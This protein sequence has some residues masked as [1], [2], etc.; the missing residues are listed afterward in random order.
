MGFTV[1]GFET[2]SQRQDEG[3]NASENERRPTDRRAPSGGSRGG[4]S[5][6]SR[7]G[8]ARPPRRDDRQVEPRERLWPDLPEDI[9]GDEL[10][11]DFIK[12]DLRPL[13][14]DNAR[15]VAK[16]LVMAARCIDEDPDLAWEHAQAAVRRAGRIGVVREAAGLAAYRAGHFAQALTELRAARRMTGSNEQLAV[17]ADCERAL[18]RPERALEI[19]GSAPAGISLATTVELRI[20]AAGARHDLGQHDAALVTVQVPELAQDDLEWGPRLR[21]AYAEA[22]LLVQRVDDARQWFLKAA[23]VDPEGLTDAEERA[24]ELGDVPRSPDGPVSDPQSAAGDNE[25]F[26]V[27]DLHDD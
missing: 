1:G 3:V 12:D 2:F 5:R 11:E 22:L 24:S 21:Y 20:V 26:Q 9:T 4:D 15:W 13:S 27:L 10:G 7:G 14:M 19:A 18:G 16:H 17:I 6:G 23:A 25:V 8:D